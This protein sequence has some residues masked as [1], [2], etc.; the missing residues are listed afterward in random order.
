[1]PSRGRIAY[2]VSLF[3]CWSETFIAEEIQSL[4]ASG[5]DVEIYSIRPPVEKEIHPLAESLMGR[6]RYASWNGIIA[7][8]LAYLFRDPRSYF[9]QLWRVSAIWRD[10]F[11]ALIKTLITFA[12]AAHFAREMRRSGVQHVHAHWATFPL[13]AAWTIKALTGLGYSFTTH[14]HDLYSPDYLL[15]RKTAAA[16]FAI[17]ISEYNRRLLRGA[18]P[19][20][21]DIHVV[22][23][24]VDTAKFAVVQD[25]RWEEKRILSVG[26]LTAIKGF[27]TL[28]EA[29][30]L[31]RDRG[32]DF[33][34]DIIGD[35]E[36]RASL[37]SQIDAAQLR[38]HV[39]L[40]GV[41]KQEEVR[42]KLRE[43]ALFVLACEQT[44]EG[45]QDGIPVALMEAM[46]CG[47]P[48]VSTRV[49]GV[50]ELIE[51]GR[52][53][54]LVKQRDAAA[55]S[56]AMELVLTDRRQAKDLALA[57]RQKVVDEFAVAANAGKIGDLFTSSM[58]RSSSRS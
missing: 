37:Q 6:T 36:L 21:L 8:N 5:F 17:T 33:R 7:A 45:Q 39:Y 9:V 10:G 50:P 24:G 30:R 28:I 34:C 43:S 15:P 27:P 51:D 22:H 46:S 49:S 4:A 20:D 48:V 42:R 41:A 32:V 1:M 38:D 18:C 12:L 47:V 54:I 11:P 52:C 57:G 35:G 55:L 40:C 25:Y 2:L 26:R 13:T 29:C 3:P 19:K 14:A 23:C 53:G 44:E 58:D 16:E 56:S 31:L